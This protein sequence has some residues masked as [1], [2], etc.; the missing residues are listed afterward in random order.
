MDCVR[1]NLSKESYLTEEVKRLKRK[2][3]EAKE[4]VRKL[5]LRVAHCV[6]EKVTQKESNRSRT[7]SKS[8]SWDNSLWSIASRS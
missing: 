7:L 3:Q 1:E 6:Q 2:V 5:E 8:S 4:R